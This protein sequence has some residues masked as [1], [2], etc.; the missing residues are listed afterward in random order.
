LLHDH[1]F[2]TTEDFVPTQIAANQ[3]QVLRHV[4]THPR[5]LG[6]VSLSCWA[7]SLGH[8]E[9]R[10]PNTPLRTLAV[11]NTDSTGARIFVTPHQ[12]YVYQGT[13]P[14]HYP[15]YFYWTAEGRSVA[16]GFITFVASGPGQKIITDAGLVPATMPVRLVQ[17]KQQ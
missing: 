15:V 8:P 11:E 3:N 14:L 5:A 6:V 2:P 4:A 7:D 17:L 13:Y 9:P 12:G 1:F 10:D 16:T